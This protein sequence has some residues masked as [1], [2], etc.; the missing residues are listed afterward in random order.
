MKNTKLSRAELAEILHASVERK[1]SEK[2]RLFLKTLEEPE[3]SDTYLRLA[4]WLDLDR[5]YTEL[6]G[7]YYANEFESD[8]MECDED[9]LLLLDDSDLPKSLY[10]TY[11]RMIPEPDRDGERVTRAAVDGLKKAMRDTLAGAR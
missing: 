8:D 10:A 7:A 1:M 4:E 5:R 11:L 6:A 9:L 3:R 2:E